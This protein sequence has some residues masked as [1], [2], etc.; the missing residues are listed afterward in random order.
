MFYNTGIGTYL[1][2]VTNRKEQRRRGKIQLVDARE[3][4]TP[5][6]SPE[7]R[8][9]M[10]GKRRHIASEQIEEI[11]RLYE[12][13]EDAER[14]KLFDNADFGYTRVTLERPLR[15]RYRMTVED[16]ARFLDACPDL[17]DD[18]QAIDEAQG[19]QPANDWNA[20]RRAYRRSP[21][22][23]R[24]ALEGAREKTLPQ[25][26]HGNGPAA[27]PVLKDGCANEYEPDPALRDFENVPLKEDIDAYFWRDVS[28]HVPDAWIDHDKD[29]IGYEI[30]FNRHFYKYTPQRPL[31]EIDADLGQA[32]EEIVRLL[33][34][35]VG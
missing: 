2:I 22:P 16:K 24:L 15:L 1:W 34:E 28:L 21:A 33:R 26:I 8:R 7:S 27:A 10:G 19:R 32:E 13:F 23:D 35:V 9:S 25:R 18:V 6:G 14:S 20:V 4:W 5:G 3:M 31:A 12:R 11:V 30:A 17:L 29:R